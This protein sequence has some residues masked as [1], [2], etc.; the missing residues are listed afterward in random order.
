MIC[1]H[2]QRCWINCQMNYS[3]KY[4]LHLIMSLMCIGYVMSCG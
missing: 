1:D 3:T 4:F 2:K